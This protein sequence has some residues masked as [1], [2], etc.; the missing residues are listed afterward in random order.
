MPGLID[1]KGSRAQDPQDAHLSDTW[2]VFPTA[3]APAALIESAMGLLLS[4]SGQIT[5]TVTLLL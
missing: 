3:Q 1:S 5:L 2:K 4:L